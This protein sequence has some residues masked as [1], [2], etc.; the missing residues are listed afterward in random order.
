MSGNRVAV[1]FDSGDNKS[2]EGN[3]EKPG[4]QPQTPPIHWVDGINA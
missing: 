2:S 4:E 3:E 1:I